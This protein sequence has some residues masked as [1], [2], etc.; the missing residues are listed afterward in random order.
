[1]E[2]GRFRGIW[3]AYG[4][5]MLQCTNKTRGNDEYEVLMDIK[6]KTVTSVFVHRPVTLNH[7]V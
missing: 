4:V 6:Q 7:F 5:S 2:E 3:T 1:M